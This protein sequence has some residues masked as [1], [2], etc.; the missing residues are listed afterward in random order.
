MVSISGLVSGIDTKAI[1][2]AY[3]QAKR[4]PIN[5]MLQTKQGIEVRIS[6]IGAMNSALNDLKTYMAGMQDISDVLSYSAKSS[7]ESILT[8]SST[9]EAAPGSYD[10]VVSS[11]ASREKDRSAAI[12]TGP[13]GQVKAGTI[14]IA[15]DD[16]SSALITIEEEDT[17]TDILNKI[18]AADVPVD[19]SIINDGTNAYLQVVSQD[20]GFK[21]GGSANDAVVIT[22]NYTGADGDELGFSQVSTA[23]NAT[24][25]LD[26][27]SI[28]KRTNSISGALTGV[29]FELLSAGSS[30][31]TVDKD[32]TGTQENVQ[33]FLDKM[34]AIR[35][36]VVD[37][38]RVDATT[39]PNTSLAGDFTIRK[40]HSDLSGLLGKT[41]P[42][43][44]NA[45]N[46]LNAIG[47]ETGPDGLLRFDT[48]K[49][50]TALDSDLNKVGQIFSQ[51]TTGVADLAIALVETY[52][53]STDGLLTSRT[54]A[55]NT[56][57]DG[58]A[59]Q[60]LRMEGRI[61]KLQDRMRAQ[62]TAMEQAMNRIQT[63]GGA[64]ASFLGTS[65]Q[66]SNN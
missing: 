58:I 33:G 28:E 23:K 32:K 37:E 29:S 59:E 57:T 49:F 50:E 41:V 21:V 11:L 43:L 8:T 26:G 46:S 36:L 20:T 15:T 17:V 62:F 7:D 63:Q 40:L 53:D 55:L 51:D 52:A 66:G 10:L 27:V 13:F 16:G 54:K 34:N 22:E 39:N 45:Y 2:N 48:D 38:M 60:V 30:T 3:V 12:S 35:Q 65:S 31:V 64:L 1:I 14:N 24:F 6:K 56:R 61:E 47:I 4:R 44:G 5:R 9:G 42:G 25:T 19:A 18:N